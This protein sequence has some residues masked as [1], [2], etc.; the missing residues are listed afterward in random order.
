MKARRI[1]MYD[2]IKPE[3][4]VVS[5]VELNELGR[6]AV[7][8]TVK[9]CSFKPQI[10]DLFEAYMVRTDIR[11]RIINSLK[12]HMPPLIDDPKGQKLKDELC[13]IV[14]TAF[15]LEICDAVGNDTPV[16]FI[17][18]DDE[19]DHM[20]RLMGYGSFDENGRLIPAEKIRLFKLEKRGQAVYYTEV[21]RFSPEESGAA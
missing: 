20:V 8:A 14:R 19:T 7:A 9:E 5:F 21:H 13:T 15:R 11:Q 12:G 1:K 6:S 18:F 17:F 16:G 10:I 4:A 2:R 3:V